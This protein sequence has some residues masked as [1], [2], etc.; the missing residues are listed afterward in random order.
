MDVCVNRFEWRIHCILYRLMRYNR[1]SANFAVSDMHFSYKSIFQY[2][3]G[4]C[5]EEAS[6]NCCKLN[7]LFVS[8]T[9]TVSVELQ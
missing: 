4:S 7:N 3:F 8:R 5:V 2:A 6:Q 1:G 9:V